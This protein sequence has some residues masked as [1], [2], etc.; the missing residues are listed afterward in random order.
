MIQL[1]IIKRVFGENDIEKNSEIY[2]TSAESG[3]YLNFR[4]NTYQSLKLIIPNINCRNSLSFETVF[5]NQFYS[6]IEKKFRTL[7]TIRD[8]IGCL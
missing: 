4:E 7:F 3:L 2:Q 8:S 6:E 5:Q 1:E